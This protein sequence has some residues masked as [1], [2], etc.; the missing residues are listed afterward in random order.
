MNIDNLLTVESASVVFIW[1]IFESL[2]FIFCLFIFV[3]HLECRYS[4][5]SASGQITSPSYP[6]NYENN[7]KCYYEITVSPGK[8]IKLTFDDF[9]IEKGP[10]CNYDFLR[11][12][13]GGSSSSKEI[14]K[15][16]GNK[17][18][19]EVLT[20][21][22]KMLVYFRSD[23]RGSK[24]GFKIT[25]RQ[26]DASEELTTTTAPGLRKFNNSWT[27]IYLIPYFSGSR[28]IRL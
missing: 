24:K 18:P 15:Y 7:K 20:T 28:D 13:D 6:A 19:G 26:V 16:C 21:G 17:S 14:G 3:Y 22:N 11:V 2:L 23:D 9:D 27:S 12:Y 8:K 10:S 5:N 1:F 4:Y 25:W